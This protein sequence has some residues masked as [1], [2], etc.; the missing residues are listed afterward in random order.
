MSEIGHSSAKVE[1]EPGASQNLWP[2]VVIATV[3]RLLLNTSRRFVYPF[4]SLFSRRLGVPL[5]AVT[6][7]IAINQMTAVMGIGA[8]PLIDR[9][10]YRRVMLA[11]MGLLCLGMGWVGLA[12]SYRGLMAALVLAGFAKT[13][14]DPAVQA[15]LGRQ[16]DFANRGAAIGSLE[17][18]WSGS[19][20]VGI[21]LAALAMDS[22][23]WQAPFMI[24]AGL[25]MVAGVGLG[26][27]FEKDVPH[28]GRGSMGDFVRGLLAVE[29]KRVVLGTM[30]WAFLLSLANDNLFV[31][32]GAWLE[33]S[34]GMGVVA[35]GLSTGLIG[36]AEMLAESFT[37]FIGDRFGLKR[38]VILGC[39]VTIVAY[40]VLPVYG[41]GAKGALVGLFILFLAFEFTMVAGI[42]LATELL[43]A[44][45]ATMMASFYAAAGLGRVAGAASGGLVWQEGGIW[46][47]G[48]VSGTGTALATLIL[49]YSLAGWNQG[50]AVD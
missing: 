7:L 39:V 13:I 2:K 35:L 31:V 48:I 10:G 17:F 18:A 3:A 26:A 42:C 50:K 25:S 45:R 43:P 21:P 47:V 9:V 11:G 49:V 5:T 14:Y 37:V 44:A 20:L 8:G 4:A 19:T 22:W 30:L 29:Q 40:F 15:Y 24:I 46:A 32:Y 28:Q 6:S 34:F 41:T 16:V 12:G 38:S 23:G 27:V 1:R 33:S 36:L